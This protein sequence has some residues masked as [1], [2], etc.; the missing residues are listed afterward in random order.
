MIRTDMYPRK[1]GA[2]KSFL[3]CSI[4]PGVCSCGPLRAMIVET[5]IQRAQPSHPKKVS[6]SLRKMEDRMA[7]ITT[8][9]APIG[10]TISASTNAYATKLH[11][12]PHI[13]IVIPV[14]HNGDLRYATPSPAACP[15]CE[16]IKPFFLKTKL[17]PI[18]KPLVTASIIP[19]TLRLEGN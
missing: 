2:K 12:S 9:S 5:I 1:P 7:H 15:A 17:E 14:H 19:T 8:D 16:R 13:I 11:N 6:F 18:N 3:N 4:S 10:V